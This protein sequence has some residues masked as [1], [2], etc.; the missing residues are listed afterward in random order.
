MTHIF[1]MQLGKV[2]IPVE[3]PEWEDRYMNPERGEEGAG[4]RFFPSY[5]ATDLDAA[6]PG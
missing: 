3:M 2:Q 5:S 4:V 1:D 6:E